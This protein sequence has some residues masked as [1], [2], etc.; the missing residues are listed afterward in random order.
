MFAPGDVWVIVDGS[1]QERIKFSDSHEAL[2]AANLLTSKYPTG[3]V[4]VQFENDLPWI[5]QESI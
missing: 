5:W 1:C 2:D 3:V 4:F